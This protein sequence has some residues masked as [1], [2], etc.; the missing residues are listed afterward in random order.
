MIALF[1]LFSQ[2]IK[3]LDWKYLKKKKKNSMQREKK[4]KL[5]EDLHH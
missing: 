4:S 5:N 2:Q 3:Y 1:F